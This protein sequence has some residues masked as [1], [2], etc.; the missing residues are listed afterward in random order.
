MWFSIN[1]GCPPAAQDKE[2]FYGSMAL[3]RLLAAVDKSDGDPS[4]VPFVLVLA[5]RR[6]GLGA[7]MQARRP[8]LVRLGAGQGSI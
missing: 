5:V 2:D 8:V 6:D 4:A 3:T 7:L 1:W